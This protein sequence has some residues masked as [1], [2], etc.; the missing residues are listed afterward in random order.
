MSSATMILDEKAST[1]EALGTYP[2]QKPSSS[3]SKGDSFSSTK[4]QVLLL[5]KSLHGFVIYSD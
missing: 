3:V 2:D 5:T 1:D 4:E